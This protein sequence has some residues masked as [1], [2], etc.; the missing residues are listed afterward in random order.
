MS[1][2]YQ[3]FHPWFLSCKIMYKDIML[4]VGGGGWRWLMSSDLCYETSWISVNSPSMQLLPKYHQ[5]SNVLTM[6][7]KRKFFFFSFVVSQKNDIPIFVKYLRRDFCFTC[8]YGNLPFCSGLLLLYFG[9]MYDCCS[10]TSDFSSPIW[11][12]WLTSGWL[13]VELS[14]LPP[15]EKESKGGRLIVDRGPG[16]LTQA[17]C[18]SWVITTCFWF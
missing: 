8:C 15:K 4:G 17:C 18:F 1:L 3:W 11:I 16:N 13:R 10:V 6:R 2:I 5:M 14:A 9:M 12:F 7:K